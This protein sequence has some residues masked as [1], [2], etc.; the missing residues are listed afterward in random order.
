MLA[1][2]ISVYRFGDPAL[3]AQRGDF[4]AMLTLISTDP[5][6]PQ[7]T[8]ADQRVARWQTRLGG[9]RWLDALV[10]S[11]NAAYTSH[12]GYPN[13]YLIRC[14]DFRERLEDGL[15]EERDIWVVGAAD[16]LTED[17]LG[18]TTIDSDELQRCDPDEWLLVEV[19]DES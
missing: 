15:P 13:N 17:W 19:W 11:R 10:E 1:W 18:K 9:A 5:D 2:L 3:R 16:I 4:D 14:K 7:A 12:G 6:L 8:D